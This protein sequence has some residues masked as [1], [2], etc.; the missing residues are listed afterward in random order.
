MAFVPSRVRKNTAKKGAKP[1][2]IDQ[3]GQHLGKVYNDVLHQPVPDRFLDLLQSLES[4]ETPKL[5]RSRSA[6][7]YGTSVELEASTTGERKKDSK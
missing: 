7:K 4:G 5:D 2:I 3:I 6:V 1:E